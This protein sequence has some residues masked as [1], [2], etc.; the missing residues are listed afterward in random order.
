MCLTCKVRTQRM[1]EIIMYT[2]TNVRTK[3]RGIVCVYKKSKNR[4]RPGS[5]TINTITS[6]IANIR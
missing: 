6:V 2:D 3:D 4:G 5:L 1:I